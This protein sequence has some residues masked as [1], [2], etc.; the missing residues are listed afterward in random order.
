VRPS[1]RLF[2][3]A[4]RRWKITTLLGVSLAAL[5]HIFT[6]T[7]VQR[8]GKVRVSGSL[9][10]TP[11]SG[12][13]SL[14]FLWISVACSA[15]A[16]V[17]WL[18]VI[19]QSLRAKRKEQKTNESA[20]PYASHLGGLVRRTTGK[21]FTGQMFGGGKASETTSYEGLKNGQDKL[22]WTGSRRNSDADLGSRSR[23][24]SRSNS[25]ARYDSEKASMMAT[26][27][28]SSSVE[29][30]PRYEPMRHRDLP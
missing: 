3:S 11:K 23:N 24:I 30:D 2:S 16:T 20:R 28:R 4:D 10:L 6:S 7:L 25:P 19:R 21:L 27:E 1:K 26:K 13:A 15:F 9:V 14:R 22:L 5:C 29:A 17:F 8:T 12:E 18:M